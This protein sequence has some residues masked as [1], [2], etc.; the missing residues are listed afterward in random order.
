MFLVSG[1]R[2]LISV[3]VQISLPAPGFQRFSPKAFFIDVAR[4]VAMIFTFTTILL[5][6]MRNILNFDR[7]D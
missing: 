6:G 2:A 4:N 1:A 5:C 7:K 3:G